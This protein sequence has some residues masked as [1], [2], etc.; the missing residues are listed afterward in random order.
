MRSLDSITLHQFLEAIGRPEGFNDEEI[1]QAGLG[2][3]PSL[4]RAL[5]RRRKRA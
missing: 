2:Q 5:A 4:F 1:E 3:D